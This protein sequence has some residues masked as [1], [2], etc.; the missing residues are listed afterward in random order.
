M[1]MMPDMDNNIEMRIVVAIAS[2]AVRTADTFVMFLLLFV[3]YIVVRAGIEI[4]IYLFRLYRER[5]FTPS[6]HMQ[7]FRILLGAGVVVLLV[8]FLLG[9][10]AIGF[11][12]FCVAS[13]AY[14][15][16]IGR[17]EKQETPELEGATLDDVVAWQHDVNAAYDSGLMERR[18]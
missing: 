8:S 18:S 15:W 17:S 16:Y 5:A 7:H 13:T 4:A 9:V 1:F 2:G 14:D 10:V 12:L 6:P 11:A 3:C